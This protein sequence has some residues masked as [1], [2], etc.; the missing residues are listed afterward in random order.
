MIDIQ[1][2][3]KRYG[4]RT[5]L[6]GVTTTLR[7]GSITWL[8]G[9]NGAGKSTL[10]RCILG[11]IEYDGRISVAG[12]D[13][14]LEGT[15][16]RALIGYMPQT[17]GLHPDLTVDE[18]LA[19][20]AGVRRAPRDRCVSLRDEA[21][22]AD[23]GGTP[24]GELS[25]GMRQRLGFAIALL[26]DPPILVLDEPTASL[27]ADSRE[28]LLQR[29]RA[30]A[31]EGRV[32]IVSTHAGHELLDGGDPRLVLEDGRVVS[33]VKACAS[34]GGT[35]GRFVP[36]RGDARGSIAPLVRKELRDAIGN[37]WLAG[38]AVLLGV[39][40]LAATATGLGSASGL[41][42]QAFGR[43]TA[44]L[45]NMCLLL[46]PLVAVLM[47]AASIAGER[48]RGTLDHLLA[49]PLTRRALLLAKHGGLLAAITGATLAGFLPAGVLI[50]A[51][52]GP[53]VIGHYLLFPAIAILAGAAMCG[54]GLLISVS[55]RSAAQAQ[56]AAIF[57][58]FCFVLLYDLILIGSLAVS[59]L[60]AGWLAVSLVLNP[61]DSARILGVLALE[62]DLYLL[63][64]AGSFLAT[65]LTPAGAAL[66]L[67]GSLLAWT[68]APVAAAVLRFNLSRR[69]AARGAAVPA[70]S[71]SSIQE[72]FS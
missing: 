26:T 10:L 34:Q 2:V 35:H 22:L 11:V 30:S 36:S 27:D 17:G 29:L 46:A 43:T 72:T 14:L 7:S 31:A 23:H 55:S 33:N 5:A 42:L 56:G 57:A 12:L 54:I 58:W 15:S 6:D 69:R 68:V 45:M 40:G 67:A 60:P 52:A 32:V 47:G 65:R 13:P 37:R 19:F 1:G 20:Y 24:V 38:Y 3:T 48:E 8:L 53:G 61:V 50:A 16:V 63:G 28:W 51:A 71:V 39:L 21:G 44:T 25:G 41:G 49:Q 66:L 4:R 59:G 64:P 18:T 70:H 9:P 62:P